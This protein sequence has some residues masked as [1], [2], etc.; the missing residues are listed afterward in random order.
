[1]WGSPS[2]GPQNTYFPSLIS[3]GGTNH[4]AGLRMRGSQDRKVA[5]VRPLYINAL[6]VQVLW[7]LSPH[8]LFLESTTLLPVLCLL[9]SCLACAGTTA[10]CLASLPLLLAP[11][12]SL[13][14]HPHCPSDG[15]KPN[16]L[17]VTFKAPA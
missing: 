11:L 4:E 2:T 8:F 17:G 12:L 14:L 10:F 5:N 1:M 9:S 13:I 3:H 7:I 15:I 6:G 16:F